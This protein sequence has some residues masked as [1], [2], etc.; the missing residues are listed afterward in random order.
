MRLISYNVLITTIQT[1]LLF[2]FYLVGVY[3]QNVFA[4]PVPGSVVGMLLLLIMLYLKWMPISWISKGASTLLNHLP[5][6]F[7]PVTVGIMQHLDFFSGKSLLLIPI[8]LLS[9]WVV[10]GITG[11][12]GQFLA[13]RRE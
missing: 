13:N 10:M 5:L 12:L 3:L 4:L 1:G 2:G 7:I 9:T 6:L 11:L 8:V